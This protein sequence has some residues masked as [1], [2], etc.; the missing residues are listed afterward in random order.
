MDGN[1]YVENFALANPVHVLR[2]ARLFNKIMDSSSIDKVDEISG[3][4]PT[5]PTSL[6]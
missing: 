5:T 4:K 2:R 6:R 1:S 3:P